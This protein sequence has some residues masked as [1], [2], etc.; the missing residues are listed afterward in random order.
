[1][2]KY[3]GRVYVY[4]NMTREFSKLVNDELDLFIMWIKCRDNFDKNIIWA[5]YLKAEHIRNEYQNKMIDYVNRYEEEDK[6]G[7]Q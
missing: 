2:T 7:V 1:M 6:L 3:K 4:E 5:E